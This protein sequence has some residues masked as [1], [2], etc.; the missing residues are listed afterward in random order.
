MKKKLILAGVAALSAVTLASCGGSTGRPA[1]KPPTGGGSVTLPTVDSFDT[2]SRLSGR[3]VNMY[4]NYKGKSGV[5]YTGNESK[6]GPT[7]A[8]PIDGN[9]YSKGDLLPMWKQVQTNLG[10]TI[11]DSVWDFTED[12]YTK[13]KE[14][15]VYTAIGSASNIQDIDIMM[16]NSVNAVKYATDNNLVNLAD[17]LQYMPNLYKF[18][19][20]HPSVYGELTD[21]NGDF[22][23]APYFDGLDTIE[24]MFIF[25]TELVEKLLDE[26][27]PTFDETTAAATAY[28][29]F[30]DTSSDYKVI[31]S[32]N[33]VAKDLTVKKATNPIAAQNALAVKNGKTYTEALR[34]YIDAAYMT[35]GQYTKRSEVF[36]SEKACYSTDDMIALMRCAVNNSVYLYGKANAVQGIVPRGQANNRVITILQL[37]Q[38]WGIRGL[39]SEKDYLYYDN[40]GKLADL[41]TSE[42]GLDALDKL[43]QLKQEGLIID[44]WDEKG[45]GAG[46]Y[47]YSYLTGEAGASL[48]IYDYNATQVVNNKLDSTTGIGTSTSKYNGLRPVLPPVTTWEDDYITDAK[49]K[50]TRYTEDSR[51]F[52]SAGSVVFKDSDEE[53]IIA[54][55]QLI[56][57]FYSEEGANLQDY[58]PAEYQDGTITVAGVTYPK[59]KL[60]VQS[61]INSSKL[62]WNDFMRD[63]IG[64]TQGIGHVRSDG[65]D[66]QVTHPVGQT[67]LN[68]VLSAIKS[69]ALVCA[70]TARNAGFGAT[71]PAYYSQNATTTDITELIDFWKQGLGD[72]AWRAVI[73]HGWES[74]TKDQLRALWET[75]NTKY[76]TFYNDYL[77]K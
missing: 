27:N 71:V 12:S 73:N 30:I 56:D 31:I 19:Q 8:N 43:H 15:D 35:S 57:Y 11:H 48:M 47:Y 53:Q 37:A 40:D 76:L 4:V 69:G 6:L 75:S 44:G 65:L 61:A 60:A 67:G 33:G 68:N 66:Y 58:G 16:T 22:Y 9:S 20:E 34:A 74:T 28:E 25:N 17:Y 59:I 49:Y 32:D 29:P 10:V 70:T 18:F 63:A 5:T 45:G 13:T 36:T 52:K 50:Y 77:G 14:D 3:T 38:I 41:R 72:T 54:S 55:C 51:A 64:S 21:E 46:T 24:K 62:G 42:K 23:I 39:T 2:Q 1:V 7:Y 26:E